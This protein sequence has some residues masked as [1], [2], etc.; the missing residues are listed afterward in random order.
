VLAGKTI[1]DFSAGTDHSVV[2][3]SDGTLAAWGSNSNGQLG[4]GGT[5]QSRVPILVDQSGVLA[6]RKVIAVAAGNFHTLAL[7][8]DG[9]LVTWGSDFAGQ[10]GDGGD[11]GASIQRPV[12]VI[13][14]GALSGKKISAISAGTS[15]NLAL[16]ED[17]TVVAWGANQ[18]GQLGTGNTAGSAEPI[19]ISAS[20]I[21]A[22]RTA[23]AIAAASNNSMVLCSDGTIATFGNNS[24]GQLG[25]GTTVQSTVPVM[26]SKSGALFGKAVTSMMACGSYCMAGLDNGDLASWGTNNN[27][28]LGDNSTVNSSLPVAVNTS[29]LRPG[30]RFMSVAG[31]GHNLALV[32]YAPPPAVVTRAA[33]QIQQTGATLNGAVNAGG[34]SVTI[35]FEYGLTTSYGNV[36]SSSPA[37]ANGTSPVRAAGK[38]TGLAP[39][40]TYHYRLVATNPLGSTPSEDMTFTTSQPPIFPGYAISTAF[41]KPVSISLRKLLANAIDPD[42]DAITVTAADSNSATGGTVVVQGSG[43]SY[44]PPAGYSGTDRFDVTITDRWGASTIGAVTVTVGNAPA[45]GG[46]TSNP[47][48]ITMLPAGR[49]GLEF[50]GIPR[51]AY[52]IQRS[53]DLATWI[54]ISSV[55]AGLS[56]EIVY[57]D[58][59]PPQSSAYYRLAAP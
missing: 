17:G 52:Q 53:G 54:T 40:T 29:A 13:E 37:T 31:S 3:C 44:T 48:K 27:Y 33:T 59:S 50:R 9:S 16:C 1:M 14:N 12:P 11:F 8:H 6:G 18:S 4:N 41:E 7:C 43:I 58:D 35:I 28:Q 10:L 38:L 39:N 56:G 46:L 51:R 24:S 15:H 2:L 45:A 42:G 34:G 49:I 5:S 30:E 57:T 47:P 22:G 25:N 21:L 23:V 26:V 32:A 20:G 19:L 55:T 36:V